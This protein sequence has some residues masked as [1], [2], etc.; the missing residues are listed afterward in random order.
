MVRT[1]SVKLAAMILTQ[2]VRSWLISGATDTKQPFTYL[3]SSSYTRHH[4]LSS[5]STVRADLSGNTRDFG[6]ETSQTVNH[7]IDGTLERVSE[8][9]P[10]SL[11]LALITLSSRISPKAGTF[12]FLL[13]SPSA[14]AVVL[15]S[16]LRHLRG[17]EEMIAYT[18]ATDRT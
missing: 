5:Q 16:Q 3:P 10:R 4:S 15:I 18:S 8:M 9:R 11:E 6:R 13:R 12:I 7:T 14:T 2:S 1:C 17:R